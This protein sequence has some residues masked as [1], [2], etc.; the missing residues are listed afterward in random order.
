VLATHAAA[1]HKANIDFSATQMTRLLREHAHR[2]S[3]SGR[4]MFSACAFLL[5][6]CRLV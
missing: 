1:E 4:L 5:R 6:G 2:F 3:M